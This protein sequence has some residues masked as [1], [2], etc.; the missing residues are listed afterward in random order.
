MFQKCIRGSIGEIKCIFRADRKVL[1]RY[2]FSG[3]EDIFS[4]TWLSE[5]DKEQ[6][7]IVFF[8]SFKMFFGTNEGKP[9]NNKIEIL[10]VEK[11]QK[12]NWNFKLTKRIFYLFKLFMI[13]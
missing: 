6:S 4:F 12:K 13:F 10:Y 5:K 7:T 1:K 11:L 2:V 8:L 9:C 3:S